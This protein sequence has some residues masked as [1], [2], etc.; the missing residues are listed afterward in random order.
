MII[1]QLTYQ[2]GVC[3]PPR[4]KYAKSGDVNI[5]YQVAG[6][7]PFDLVL[8]PGWISHLENAWEES[9]FARFLQRLASLNDLEND[10]HSRAGSEA[11]I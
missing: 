10:Y 5:A 2:E 1:A 3:M 4:T 7:G 6:E 11:S 9:S 8:V